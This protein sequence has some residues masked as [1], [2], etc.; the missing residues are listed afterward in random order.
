MLI[1]ASSKT[2]PLD[3]STI[4]DLISGSL[5]KIDLKNKRILMI[6]PDKTRHCPLPII[7]K[8]I[9][10]NLCHI[11]KKLDVMIALGTHQP[12]SEDE[13]LK[14]FNLTRKEKAQIKTEFMNHAWDDPSALATIGKI[15][16]GEVN[17]LTSGLLKEEVSVNINKRIFEYDRIFIIGPTFPHEVAGFSGGYKYFFPGIAGQ[18]I[19][20]FFHWVGA[21]VTN[22]KINGVKETPVR[23]VIEKCASFINI[24]VTCFSLVVDHGTTFGLFIGDEPETWSAAA[25]LSKKLQIV[26]LNKPY[27]RVL[28]I[29]PKIYDELW[30]GAKVM[31]KLESV[32]ENGGELII[33]APHIK[34]ISFTHG[35]QIREI[36]YHTRDYFL[37][38][39]DKFKK[40]PRGILAH[41]THVKGMGTYENGVEKPRIKV[42]LATGIPESVCKKINLGYLDPEE[43]SLH[44]WEKDND[45]L[46]VQEAGIKLYKLKGD[47]SIGYNSID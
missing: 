18:E 30:T 47:D 12:M 29:C 34:E 33:Y 32:V 16:S 24:P 43:V 15:D 13:I 27:K 8:T 45:N 41:S 26:Y 22:V 1:S 42:T 23:K 25:D 19:I 14:M 40:Y 20:H 6:V 28:G 35:K 4:T 36:G 44:E 5:E 39:W 17:R 7:F 46:L 10:R 38:Q 2:K 21:L 11:V 3:E 37:M 9:Y 31:Y